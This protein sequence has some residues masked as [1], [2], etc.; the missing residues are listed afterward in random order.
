MLKIGRTVA[1]L[2][3]TKNIEI[4]RVTKTIQYRSLDRRMQVQFEVVRFMP[5]I[6]T[7]TV[8]PQVSLHAQG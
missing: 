4:F 7:T 5:Q 2:A 8:W 1:E 6:V 3:G